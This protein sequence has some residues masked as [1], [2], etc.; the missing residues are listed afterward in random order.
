MSAE[1]QVTEVFNDLSIAYYN[2]AFR[3]F[4][5]VGSSRSSKS[6]SILQLLLLEMMSRPDL[7]ITVWRDMKNVCRATVREDFRKIILF[8]DDIYNDIVENKQ[9]GSF[10]YIPN[11]SRIIFDGADNIGKVLGSAQDISFFNEVSEFS[12]EVYLQITQRTADKVFC[13]YNPSKSF[14][15]EDYREDEDTIFLHSTFQQ[16]SFCPEPIAR[17]LLSYNPWEVGSYE[18][19]NGVPMYGGY[20]ISAKNQPPPNIENI[21]RKTANPFMWQVYG[22]GVQA[23]KPTRIY[24]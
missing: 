4:V 8:D 15:L 20:P 23:E 11:G 14:W 1:L 22:L 9:D 16:N 18:V 10:T 13:D 3:Q 19:V 2:K 7:K 24:R 17:Q 6:F 12:H 5:L 21:R